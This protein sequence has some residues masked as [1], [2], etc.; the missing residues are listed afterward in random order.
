MNHQLKQL[1]D[2]FAADAQ[3]AASL[4]DAARLE[5]TYLGRKAGKLTDVL[6]NLKNVPVA[7]RKVV[8]PA[9]NQLKQTI[10]EKIAVLKTA[11]DG[12]DVVIIKSASEALST[13]L[14]KIGEIMAKAAQSTSSADKGAGSAETEN[15][16]KGDGPVRDAEF[17]EGDKK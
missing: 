15:P 3:K 12:N 8:G 5:V 11:K 13:E 10:E 16:D 9:A 14:Q 4:D 17:K 1:A 2:A 7:E 6:R